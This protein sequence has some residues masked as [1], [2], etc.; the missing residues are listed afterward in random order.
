[1]RED[2]LGVWSRDMCFFVNLVLWVLFGGSR[3]VGSYFLFVFLLVSVFCG[4]CEN[5]C[6]GFIVGWVYS[7]DLINVDC[8]GF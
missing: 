5:V 1:M 8:C 2:V 3:C 7:N 4:L 6:G